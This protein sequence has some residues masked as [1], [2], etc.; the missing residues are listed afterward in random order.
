MSVRF[1]VVFSCFLRG[2]TPSEVLEAVRW[3]L[4]LAA[5]RPAGLDPA[6]HPDRLLE[7]DE[8]S[9]LPGGDVASLRH[10]EHGFE[11]FGRLGVWGLHSRNY[12]LDDIMGELVTVLDLLAP[13]AENGYG[14]YFRAETEVK[15]TVLVFR[16]GAYDGV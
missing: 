6:E 5:E 9:C 15:P 14:G 11:D 2:D 10:R 12:W 4:G 7:T 3:H 8:E 1:E 16:D 13:Y